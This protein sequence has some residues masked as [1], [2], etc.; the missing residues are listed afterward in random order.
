MLAISS[1]K[2]EPV[3]RFATFRVEGERL[4][5]DEITALLQTPPT[6]AYQKGEKVKFSPRSP[7]TIAKTGVWFLSTDKVVRSHV[8]DDH[9]R[10]VFRL[11]FFPGGDP[12]R[13]S[14]FR[15]L[16]K[17]QGLRAHLTIFAH[18]GSKP[19]LHPSLEAMLKTIPADVQI[20]F[21]SDE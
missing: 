19:S 3:V 12:L 8:L 4:V 18:G 10:Y 2:S 14:S 13:V 16:L 1:T 21:D 20:D 9:L 7:K 6:T 5:P 11:A 15:D 17:K